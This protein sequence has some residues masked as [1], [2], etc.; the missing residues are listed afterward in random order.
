[1]NNK[2]HSFLS[3]GKSFWIL[4]LLFF[5]I[6]LALFAVINVVFFVFSNTA[7]ISWSPSAEAL[8][9]LLGFPVSLAGSVVAII[10]AQRAV[11]ISHRQEQQE[12]IKNL[13]KLT[14]TIFTEY[15]KISDSLRSFIHASSDIIH[16]FLSNYDPAIDDWTDDTNIDDFH[17]R[18]TDLKTVRYTFI[19]SIIG[20]NKSEACSTLMRKSFPEWEDSMINEVYHLIEEGQEDLD[21]IM[22]HDMFDPFYFLYTLDT[23]GFNSF[24]NIIFSILKRYFSKSTLLQLQSNY[25]YHPSEE[26]YTESQ[27]LNAGFE[28]AKSN[29]SRIDLFL[30]TGLFVQ[31][32]Y[33]PQ[34]SLDSSGDT[35]VASER[36][37]NDG[38]AFIMDFLD[39]LPES[40]GISSILFQYMDNRKL[41]EPALKETIE[42]LIEDRRIIDMYPKWMRDSKD[43]IKSLGV[44]MLENSIFQDVGIRFM[45]WTVYNEINTQ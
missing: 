18:C 28:I 41:D 33:Y 30:L 37:T 5:A 45:E 13:E 19:D 22:L 24:Q 20:L 14:D 31:E 2:Q 15:W 6:T 23:R 25:S 32:K 12:I 38:A 10:L 16:F 36:F 44:S 21:H 11:D 29:F 3:P 34:V 35:I 39:S 4:L 1:M 27:K 40:I 42:K 9:A 17:A 8:G 26:F 7:S 43:F